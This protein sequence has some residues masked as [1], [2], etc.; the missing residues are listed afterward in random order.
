MPAPGSS[1]TWD[2]RVSEAER[3]RRAR[4]CFEGL[5][6]LSRPERES[7]LAA[8]DDAPLRDAVWALLR[9][10]DDP[11]EVLPLFAQPPEWIG[12]FRVLREIGRGG[13]GVVYEA[14]EVAPRRRVALKLLHAW[15]RSP[16]VDDFARREAQA[17]ADA[18]H[19]GIPSVYALLDHELGP[20]VV[21]EL[22]EGE[23]FGEALARR[24]V[25]ERLEL[26][27]RVG[28]AIAYAH[29]R[30]VIHRDLK[31][32]NVILAA[33]DQP[34]ILDFGLANTRDLGAT[35]GG[36]TPSYMAPEQAA[37]AEPTP[38]ADLYSL[39]VMASELVAGVRLGQPGGA[40]VRTD[41]RAVLARATAANAAD[42]YPSVAT[43]ADELRRAAQNHAV[44][45]HPGVTPWIR[46]LIRRHP[47]R[48]LGVAAL[49]ALAALVPGM[50]ERL[51][52][53]RAE[54]HLRGLRSEAEG[55]GNPKILELLEGMLSDPE[56][57]A[58]PAIVEAWTW[59][60]TTTRSVGERLTS[61]VGAWIY[62]GAPSAELRALLAASLRE[63]GSEEAASAVDAEG[64]AGTGL[65]AWDLARPSALPPLT[66][67]LQALSAATVLPER[68]TDGGLDPDSRWSWVASTL[69]SPEGSSVALSGSPSDIA[70]LR[71]AG[72]TPLPIVAV[73][74]E[75]AGL[76]AVESGSIRPWAAG[77]IAQALPVRALA[78]ADLDGDGE[79]ELVV[80]VTG[81]RGHELRVL[82]P[83]GSTRAR[84]R[85]AAWDVAVT[86]DH[87][88][89]TLGGPLPTTAMPHGTRRALVP[90]RLEGNGLVAAGSPIVL[91]R[92]ATGLFAADV[93]GNGTDELILRRADAFGVVAE[94][95]TAWVPGLRV[96]SRMQFDDDP[97]AELRVTD[98]ARDWVL[99]A[100]AATLPRRTGGELRDE[101]APEALRSARHRAAWGRAAALAR[102][103]VVEPILPRLLDL[104]RAAAHPA[105][106]RADALA[107]ATPT[108]DTPAPGLAAF[109]SALVSLEPAVPVDEPTRA[110]LRACH[111]LDAEGPL[112]R[113]TPTDALDLAA[114]LPAWLA[115]GPPGTVHRDPLRARLRIDLGSGEGAAVH[116]EFAAVSDAI[117]ADVTLEIEEMDWAAGVVLAVGDGAREATATL[118][119]T[120]G[121]DRSGHRLNLAG[122]GEIAAVQI[123]FALGEHRVSVCISRDP[124]VS[125]AR[126]DDLPRRLHR[127][128]VP[129][130]SG[131]M[132]LE[133]R[134]LGAE[135]PDPSRRARVHLSA[136]TL[137]GGQFL[138]AP[139][140]EASARQFAES[141]MG[142]STPRGRA[143]VAAAAGDIV[144]AEIFAS[145][146]DADA[147]WLLRRDAERWAPVAAKV[148]G[149]QFFD[150]WV[151]AWST[152][153][154]YRDPWAAAPLR[155]T[156]LSGLPVDTPELQATALARSEE[157]L[158]SGEVTAAR[159]L[160]EALPL[161][162]PGVALARARIAVSTGHPSDVR[163]LLLHALG[164]SVAPEPIRDAFA[165]DPLLAAWVA[166][167]PAAPVLE[168]P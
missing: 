127:A 43:F 116:A 134:A 16:A 149:A 70:V 162:S 121:G 108:G 53:F 100:G 155:S 104:A 145:L 86:E 157:L 13:M 18:P 166:D 144:S 63:N 107:L 119:R 82:R 37:G 161:T 137:H 133:L 34:K 9:A 103:G 153:V 49:T 130:L 54:T 46:A 27:A 140:G 48:L 109:A 66:R 131:A 115:V 30:G 120:G 42:R 156:A 60:A 68:T 112:R 95:T 91:D 6:P 1:R 113:P 75:G 94:H 117:C 28:D 33:G 125:S 118:W 80:G 126:L 142:A 114:P 36:G 110:L 25:A 5:L 67:P 40:E 22:V 29:A 148:L 124:A 44:A 93:D 15:L 8:L 19:P 59:R 105:A 23:P 62:S 163:P 32:Q 64:L 57:L 45:A 83:D 164:E 99:G 102:L 132:T 7:A 129:T 51:A 92:E 56:L 167:V 39:G 38:L 61:L 143:L 122:P 11:R 41:I 4:E 79:D 87:T 128:G 89:W 98:G 12:S 111:A 152:P 90:L 24:P 35:A 136:L 85:F 58:S 55:L 123:P 74:F 154:H 47:R 165:D 50:P 158:R 76:Y 151:R 106:L 139:R 168:V 73:R 52:D 160:L 17:L 2:E 78:A 71:Q 65:A 88:I 10:D 147:V 26:L 97:A 20:V 21:M 31:P 14:E 3:Y 135:T 146:E 72:R 150:T 138:S 141:E 77:T 159:A 81:W 84:V 69:R 101:P 96:V